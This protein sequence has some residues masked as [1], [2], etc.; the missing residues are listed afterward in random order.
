MRAWRRNAWLQRVVFKERI[1]DGLIV[2]IPTG[3]SIDGTC[4]VASEGDGALRCWFVEGQV[5]GCVRDELLFGGRDVFGV[6]DFGVYSTRNAS[7]GC[8]YSPG[9]H[10]PV[11]AVVRLA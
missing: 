3:R 10:E 9:N 1:G 7:M 5:D 2:P 4:G 11:L 6:L 8:A